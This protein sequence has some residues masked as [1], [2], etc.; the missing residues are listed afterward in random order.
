[1]TSVK[2][3][4]SRCRTREKGFSLIEMLMVVAI[5][6]IMAAISFI[7]LV[8]VM[9][10]Q[11]LAN[12]YNTTLSAMRQARDNS[13]SQRTSYKVTFTST[14]SPVSNTIKVEPTLATFAGAQQTATYQL[15][16]DVA[17]LVQTG[18]PA[19]GPDGYGTGATAIDFGYTASHT[20]GGSQIIYFCPDGS[21]QD[22][23]TGNCL[24]S[25]DGGVVYMSRAGDLLSSRAITLWG[26]T[27]RIRGWRLYNTG[28]STYQWFRQ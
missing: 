22:D 7:S 12:A 28:G 10:Q 23:N 1:M 5:V 17:F 6:I 26:A 18:L 2:D 20:T 14:T 4:S 19:T 21:A 13:I 24:G 9:K 11:R 16:T 8:P 27:G 25:A 15:P 3:N